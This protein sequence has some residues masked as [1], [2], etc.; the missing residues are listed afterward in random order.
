MPGGSEGAGVSA[1]LPNTVSLRSSSTVVVADGWKLRGKRKVVGSKTDKAARK[2]R[3]APPC[4]LRQNPNDLN[5]LR[6]CGCGGRCAGLRKRAAGRFLLGA[7]VDF[8]GAFEVGAVFDHDARRRQVAVHG[9][10]F[11]DF[12]PVLG[13]KIALHAAV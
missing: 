11:F 6:T 7:L 3:L 1:L 5:A 12:D 9:A 10:V 13:A 2:Y 8:D 4:S